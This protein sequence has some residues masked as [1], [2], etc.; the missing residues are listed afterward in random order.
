[1]HNFKF[2]AISPNEIEQ[3]RDSESDGVDQDDAIPG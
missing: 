1:M 3:G 2:P